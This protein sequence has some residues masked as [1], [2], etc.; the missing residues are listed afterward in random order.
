MATQEMILKLS[1]DDE[2]TFTGLEDINQ[3]IKKVDDSTVHL[4]KSTKTL[5]AQYADLKKQQDQFDPGTE[6]FNQLSIKMGE[7]KDRMND[8]AEA[9]KVIQVLLLKV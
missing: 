6:K 7:L 3:E 9:V 1:F 5:K 2:G 8:A 4:E